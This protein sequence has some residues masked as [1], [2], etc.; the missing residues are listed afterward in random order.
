MEAVLC[1]EYG[2]LRLERCEPPKRGPG[3][4]RLGVRAASVGFADTL[5]VKGA[6]QVKTP[7]PFIPGTEAAGVVL[8]K[9][10]DVDGVEVG[11]RVLAVMTHD[12]GAWA[13]QCVINAQRVI[14]LPDGMSFEEAACLPSA[15]G[16]SY[17][18]LRQRAQLK[19]GEAVA[20]LGAAGG[21]GLA[22]V[23]LAKAMGA[24][25]IAAAS[26]AEKL[27]LAR[28]HG[29]D[30]VINYRNESLKEAVTRLTDGRGADVVFDPV[31]GEL[32]EDAIRSVAFEGRVLIVGFASGTIPQARMNHVLL[33]GYDLRGVRY[34]TWR[35]NN[36]EAAKANLRDI[37]EWHEQDRL[38]VA[39]T[40]RYALGDAQHALADLAGGKAL[41]KQV[42]Q[43]QP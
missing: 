6:Y 24:T 36:L 2:H 28:A 39:V 18:A 20:V 40:R 14:K 35:D 10:D 1:H 15:Y 43:I 38:Q 42:F 16:T 7:V 30:H 22:A 9:D 31:G 25:V 4:L 3:Q 21:V 32:F 19:P 13:Q 34:D 5:K 33:K 26:T 12:C 11:D 29:A 23:S 27:E 17:Y 41:G 8:E 37:L